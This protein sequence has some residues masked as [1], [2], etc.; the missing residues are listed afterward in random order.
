M[1]ASPTQLLS[2]SYTY[3]TLHSCRLDCLLHVHIL[4]SKTQQCSFS[5]TF[6]FA[7]S[8]YL[9]TEPCM[10]MLPWPYDWLLDGASIYLAHDALHADLRLTHVLKGVVTVLHGSQLAEP[11]SMCIS[12][13]FAV[14]WLT[15]L[16]WVWLQSC[17]HTRAH[18]QFQL[19]SAINGRMSACEF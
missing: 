1:T 4:T 18:L 7:L 11:F 13:S 12:K 19:L 9:S 17:L 8:C 10:H 16:S 6:Q 5:Y 15:S 2:T 14:L 3:A